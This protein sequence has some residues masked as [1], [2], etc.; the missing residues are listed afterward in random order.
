MMMMM[1][2]IKISARL[3]PQRV[4]PEPDYHD[5]KSN[6]DQNDHDDDHLNSNNHEDGHPDHNDHEDDQQDDD[7]QD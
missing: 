1:M 7:D 3:L 4:L 5:H 6:L 2:M